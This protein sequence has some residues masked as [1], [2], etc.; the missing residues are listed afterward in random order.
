MTSTRRSASSRSS[1][2][3]WPRSATSIFSALYASAPEQTRVSERMM[4]SRKH[5][6]TRKAVAGE[7]GE[8]RRPKQAAGGACT[9]APCFCSGMA[10]AAAVVV[11]RAQSDGTR[12]RGR[13]RRTPNGAKAECER[14]A[15][16]QRERKRPACM[17]A[18]RLP[19][20]RLFFFSFWGALWGESAVRCGGGSCRVHALAAAWLEELGG[21]EGWPMSRP[22]VLPPRVRAL[23]AAQVNGGAT[24]LKLQSGEGVALRLAGGGMG[25]ENVALR[26]TRNQ[27]IRTHH[28]CT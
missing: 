14:P 4:V 26:S 18:S 28:D 20:L 9:A 7:K 24:V 22:F 2:G 6:E 16:A 3:S 23:R 19:S 5:R 10:A 11:R 1:G 8:R 12:A 13:G 17:H 15:T 27:F 21:D 25:G